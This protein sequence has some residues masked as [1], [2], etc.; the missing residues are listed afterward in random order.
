MNAACSSVQFSWIVFGMRKKLPEAIVGPDQEEGKD[1]GADAKTSTSLA[2]ETP[3]DV[4]EDRARV[5][6]NCLK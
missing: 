4:V 1:H 6:E 3:L 5:S 2:G